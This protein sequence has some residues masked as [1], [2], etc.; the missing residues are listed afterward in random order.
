MPFETFV[1]A[2]SRRLKVKVTHEGQIIK[3]VIDQNN[4]A[5][6]FDLMSVM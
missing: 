4:L 1:H 6:L 2:G 3:I 5:Q